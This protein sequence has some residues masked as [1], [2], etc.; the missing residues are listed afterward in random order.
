M[1][2]M[3]SFDCGEF[4]TK[5]VRSPR[6]P[7]K[8]TIGEARFSKPSCYTRPVLVGLN[9]LDVN[10]LCLKA[11]V[12]S[13]GD[14]RAILNM[15]TWGNTEHFGS[16]CS[17]LSPPMD[18]LDIQYG[19]Y[20]IPDDHSDSTLRNKTSRR[21]TFGRPYAASPKVVVWLNAADCGEG[22]PVR[23]D[24]YADT[25]TPDGFTIHVDT[26][27]DSNL[28]SAGVTWLAHSAHRTDVRSGSFHTEQV[29]PT[30]DRCHTNRGRVSWGVPEMARPPRVFT[31]LRMLDFKEGRNVRLIMRTDEITTTG[32]CWNLDSRH[33][34][35]F[36]K[37][38]AVFVA[39]DDGR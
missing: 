39:F 20:S 9:E 16:G 13:V 32:M 10:I 25:V 35:V 18:D 37:G 12:R 28:Y 3:P 26:W 1:P 5:D 36:Y 7:Q 30:Q 21:I 4:R 38:A 15:N 11:E 29:R 17:W 22:K 33:D 8:L 6:D 34:T 19:T 2:P 14:D 31:A 24:A 27:K 23:V